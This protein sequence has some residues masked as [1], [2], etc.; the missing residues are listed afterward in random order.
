MVDL[1][2]TFFLGVL[3]GMII[4]I[5]SFFGQDGLI[6]AFFISLLMNGISY[7]FSDKIV[8]AMYGARILKETERPELHKTVK[9]LA[10]EMGL[11]EPK[12]AIIDMKTPNAFATGRNPKNSVIALTTGVIDLLSENELKGVISH[13]LS[14]VKSRDTLVSTIAAVM[15]SV[16][17]YFSY[18]LRYT[19]L[20]GRRDDNDNVGRILMA[21]VAPISATL[22]RLAISRNREFGADKS[23][24]VACKHPEYLASALEKINSNIQR[25][26]L[27][28]GNPATSHLFIVNP[29]NAR[30]M[31]GLFSTH[32]PVEERVKRLQ[33]MVR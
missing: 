11:P 9:E 25:F 19:V 22:I 1:K 6:I 13:E 18:S 27:T 2:T 23:G 8:L 16:I 7:F 14:H 10:K 26:P 12:I 4:L 29:F 24:A 21:F 30:T 28:T 17:T 3:S 5:G 15:A 32:P 33:A 31:L 20:S